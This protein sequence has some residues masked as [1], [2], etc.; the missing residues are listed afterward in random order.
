MMA[1]KARENPNT[2]EL[3]R[4]D[5]LKKGGGSRA[6]ASGMYSLIFSFVSSAFLWIFMVVGSGSDGLA[7]MGLNG[8]VSGI[9]GIVSAGFSQGYIAQV[10]EAYL[11]N[12]QEGRRIASL[13]NQFL[14]FYGLI[15]AGV[16]LTF[17]L[18]TSDI[19]LKF[20]L[21]FTIPQILL[22]YCLLSSMSWSL[23]VVN[24]YD[25]TSFVGAVGGASSLGYGLVLI[26]I[27]APPQYF[28]LI[29]SV[30]SLTSLPVIWIFF[31]RHS[32]FKLKELLT[33]GHLLRDRQQS[34]KTLRYAGLTTLSNMESF[35]LVSNVNM[36]VTYL[37]LSAF[38]SEQEALKSMS[39]LTIINI[40]S[41]LKC[42]LNLFSSPLNVE[43]AEAYC[44]EDRPKMKE[45]INHAV[46]FSYLVGFALIIGFCGLAAVILRYLHTDFFTTGGTFDEPL[47]QLALFI[48]II[49]SFGQAGF[50]VANLYANALIG[51][52]KAAVSAKVYLIVLLISAILTPFCVATLGLGI[53][54]IAWSTLVVGIATGAIMQQ[55]V[56]KHLQVQLDT[57]FLNMIPMFTILFLIM[58]FFPYGDITGLVFG[59]IGI[60]IAI[61][62]PFYI[63]SLSFFGVFHDAQDWIVVRDMYVSLGM[64]RF[65]NPL[66]K[67]GQFLYRLN[68]FNRRHQKEN[69]MK[70]DNQ[71]EQS[72]TT[73]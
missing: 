15:A 31:R 17:G 37:S 8:N 36:F 52:E 18:I 71:K 7:Y 63:F 39:M 72:T 73:G 67:M 47:F 51:T 16:C 35:Q 53:S 26:A 60:A 57:H 58:F 43:L 25:L 10:K 3:R 55:K 1:A 9:V 48:A 12:P 20:T 56:K 38:F 5:I 34:F 6:V 46:K 62:V 59:D 66:V 65:A 33:T 44:K 2:C 64:R 27:Q 24:R 42:S 68:P 11:K 49:M 54:G 21:F 69:N 19:P 61:I 41:Q 70:E 50:G 45:I 40:Y 14:I 29:G 13:Y 32:P 4:E 22:N 30:N 28:A 23:S